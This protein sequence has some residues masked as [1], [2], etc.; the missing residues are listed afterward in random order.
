[1]ARKDLLYVPDQPAGPGYHFFNPV[2]PKGILAHFLDIILGILMSAFLFVY[3]VIRL[4]ILLFELIL[5]VYLRIIA[6]GP[7]ITI[8]FGVLLGV[9]ISFHLPWAELW[10]FALAVCSAPVDLLIGPYCDIC[11]YATRFVE[12]TYDA[13]LWF[14]EFT[15]RALEWITVFVIRFIN[16][17]C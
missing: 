7:Y 10:K 16:N 17:F 13:H 14:A 11:P 6:W 12:W 3:H 8:G 4:H 5:C 15:S 2:A 9:R 1:M